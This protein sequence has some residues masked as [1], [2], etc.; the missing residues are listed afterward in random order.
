MAD[1]ADLDARPVVLHRLLHAPLDGVLI[2]R[3]LH[4]DEVDHDQPSEVAKAKLAGDLV[5]RLD[6]GLERRLLDVALAGGAAGVD[7]DGDQRLGLVQYDVTA[8]SE[9]H[10]SELQSLMRISYAV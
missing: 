3:L 6:V 8:R 5:G 9:E 4:V 1:P 2:A 10:T 7:V